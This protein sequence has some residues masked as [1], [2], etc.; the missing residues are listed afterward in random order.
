VQARADQT[1]ALTGM[2]GGVT[3][4]LGSMAS[5]GAF[6]GGGGGGGGA[7]AGGRGIA[8]GLGG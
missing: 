6:S 8:A 1:S 2:I 5:S 4:S 7:A 3:S